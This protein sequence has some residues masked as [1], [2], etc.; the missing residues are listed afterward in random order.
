MTRTKQKYENTKKTKKDVK[1]ER[2]GERELAGCSFC[3]LFLFVCS[4]VWLLVFIC[5]F[6]LFCVFVWLIARR[7]I[8][9]SGRRGGRVRAD[10]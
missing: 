10:L 8:R 3:S 1:R 9:Q 2:E 4:T 7:M 5:L 6:V